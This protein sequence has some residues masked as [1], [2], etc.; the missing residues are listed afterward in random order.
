MNDANT[1]RQLQQLQSTIEGQQK[2]INEVNN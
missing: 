2:T 1:K